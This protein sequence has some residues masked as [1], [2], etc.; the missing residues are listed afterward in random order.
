M[1]GTLALMSY[2]IYQLRESLGMP[3]IGAL[4]AQGM[5]PSNVPF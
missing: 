5:S 2:L 1:V 4:A 3:L